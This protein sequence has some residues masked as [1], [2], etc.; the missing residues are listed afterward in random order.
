MHV[1]RLTGGLQ[2]GSR[3]SSTFR[4]A[5]VLV[6][7]ASICLGSPGSSAYA[8]RVGPAPA[9]KVSGDFNG[10]GFSDLA[11]GVPGEGPLEEEGA[12]QVLYGSAQ[13]LKAAHNQVWTQDSTGVPGTGEAGDLFGRSL[14]T[15]DFNGDGFADLAAESLEAAAGQFEA[16]AVTVLYGSPGGLTA[17]GSVVLTRQFVGT[18]GNPDHFGWSLAAGNLGGGPEAELVAG[19]P[20]A[21][22]GTNDDAG[23]FDVFD[24]SPTGLAQGAMI[25]FDLDSPGIPGDAALGDELGFSTATGQLGKSAELDLVVGAPSLQVGSHTGAGS[26][27]VMYG[28]PAGLSATGSRQFDEGTAGVPGNPQTDGHFGDA[29]RAGSFGRSSEFDLAVGAPEEQIGTVAGAG[30]VTVLYGS[31]TGLRSANAQRFSQATPGMA[32][33]PGSSDHF[34]SSLGA[35]NVGRSS[36][37]DLVVGVEFDTFGGKANA[38][39]IA[40]LYGSA[41]GLVVAGNQVFN[42]DT[43]GVPSVAKEVEQFGAAVSVGQFGRNGPADVAVGV[44]FDTLPGAGFPGGVNVLYGS[45]GG[46]SPTGSQLW[47]EDSSGVLGTAHKDEEFGGALAPSRA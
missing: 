1:R 25:E 19:V 32:G 41:T 15:G 9:H 44:P 20:G 2:M 21:D 4:L 27:L 7:I 46:L 8:G 30:S 43:P 3:R 26:V 10:D 16:G 22:P 40:V 38:G 11:I 33:D 34:G 37:G 6:V 17:T 23:A 47:N 29:V 5:I 39:S 42:Q 13:G 12:V 28:T 36:F 31:P 35:G 14:A 45:G 18:L 24:G